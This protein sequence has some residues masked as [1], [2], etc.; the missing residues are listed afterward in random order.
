MLCILARPLLYLLLCL[1]QKFISV[2]AVSGSEWSESEYSEGE[3]LGFSMRS[4]AD[5]DEKVNTCL[6]PMIHILLKILCNC[7]Y[8][9]LTKLPWPGDSEE[10][11]PSLSQAAT[12]FPDTVEAS[13]CPVN[14]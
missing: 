12:C 5:E 6:S 8:I 9:L 4:S 13:R 11:F 3:S 14:C 1:Y 7:N 10:T 2:S